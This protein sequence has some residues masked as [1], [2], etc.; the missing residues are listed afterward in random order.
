MT[1]IAIGSAAVGAYGQYQQGKT[2]QTM[3]NYEA[4]QGEADARAEAKAAIV[5]ADM[6]RKRGAQAAAEANAEVAA[7]GN[8]LASAGALAINREIYRGAEE[9][10][11]F[12]LIGG[13]DRSQRLM[14]SAQ[15]DK[16]RGASAKQA[17][18]FGA[19]TTLGQGAVDAYSGWKQAGSPTYIGNQKGP[20]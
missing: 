18:I 14:A 17:G 4:K 6:I 12:A 8:Q 13:K 16:M 19:V 5:E 2:Q 7:S 10:A 1:V 15:L 3:Y 11:Y 9:D 20:G